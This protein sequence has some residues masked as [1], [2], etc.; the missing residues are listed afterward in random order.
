MTES[1]PQPTTHEE[2]IEAAPE[3]FRPV[4]R[5]LRERIRHEVPDGDEIVAYGMPGFRLGSA[6]VAGD[7]A[8]SKQC[9]L[10]LSAEAVAA[11][12]EKIAAAGLKHTKTGITLSE[13]RPIPDELLTALLAAARDALGSPPS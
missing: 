3:R 8:F 4:L 5:A 2:Y 6:T 10:Y 9:G 13:R 7:A 12:S 11:C 1:T